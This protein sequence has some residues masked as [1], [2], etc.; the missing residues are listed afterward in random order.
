M[1]VQSIEIGCPSTWSPW[2][3]CYQLYRICML[4]ESFQC[5]WQFTHT[6]IKYTMQCGSHIVTA[7]HHSTHA[8]IHDTPFILYISHIYE[9]ANCGVFPKNLLKKS[10]VW[11]V[12]SAVSR[13]STGQSAWARERGQSYASH[14]TGLHHRHSS[15]LQEQPW[16]YIPHPPGIKGTRGWILPLRR[17]SLNQI[18]RRKLH[19]ATSSSP[20]STEGRL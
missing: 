16:S 7:P 18:G 9:V 2:W 17:G 20:H 15:R 12:D 8:H 5:A 6:T 3:V 1:L 10:S 11:S 13:S 4:H 19:S 14:H